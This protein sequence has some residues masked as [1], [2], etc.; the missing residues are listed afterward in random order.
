MPQTLVSYHALPKAQGYVQSPEGRSLFDKS[1]RGDSEAHRVNRQECVRDIGSLIQ[2]HES[3]TKIMINSKR[4]PCF[5]QE[6]SNGGSLEFSEERA[7]MNGSEMANVSVPVQ[8]LSDN[9]ESRSLLKIKTGRRDQV[10][11]GQEI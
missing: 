2:D 5:W 3:L 7:S 10:S 9:C 6:L 4:T 11:C 8:L 1:A